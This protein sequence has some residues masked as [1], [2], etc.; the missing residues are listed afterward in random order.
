MPRLESP[1][2]RRTALLTGSG[3]LAV[4]LTGCRSEP[5]SAPVAAGGPSATST[6]DP[7]EE[8]VRRARD[9]ESQLRR[10]A[11]RTARRHPGLRAVLRRTADVHATHTDL[12]RESID[13]A[14]ADPVVRPVP[15]DPRAAARGLAGRERALADAHARAAVDARS[16]PLARVLAGMAAAADQQAFMLDALGVSGGARG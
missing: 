2:T 8:L 14:G 9:G 15:R 4:V 7:D 11:L 12:L 1:L 6:P 16:G 3:S 5:G 13:L 10:D